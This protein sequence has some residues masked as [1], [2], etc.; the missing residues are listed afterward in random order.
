MELGKFSS[1]FN[2]TNPLVT[3][4]CNLMRK[5]EFSSVNT[6]K[7]THTVALKPH[8]PSRSQLSPMLLPHSNL[9]PALLVNTI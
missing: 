1:K 2:L 9:L 8:M 3:C 7:S 4:Y 5:V 6:S